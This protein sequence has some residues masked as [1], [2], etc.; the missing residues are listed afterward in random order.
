MD[1]RS[2]Q[3]PVRERDE[4]IRRI[5]ET[6]LDAVVSMDAHGFVRYWNTPAE[7]MFGWTSSEVIGEDLADLIMPERFR[8]AHRRGIKR[9]LVTG[10][11]P[12]LGRRIET[13]GLRRDGREFPIELSV[14]ALVADG[15]HTFNAFISDITERKQAEQLLRTGEAHKTSLLR[16]S[17]RLEES[18]SV[19]AVLDAALTEVKTVMGYRTLW[20]YLLAPDGETASL[21]SVAGDIAGRAEREVPVLKVRGDR[22]LEACFAAHDVLV[23]DDAAVD[24]RTNKG[25]VAK[26]EVRTIVT[27]PMLLADRRIGTLGTGSVGDEGVRA[28]DPLQ[29]DYF[30]ALA[31]HV[32]VACGRIRLLSD[33]ARAIEEARGASAA[34]RARLDVM[35]RVIDDLLALMDGDGAQIGLAAVQRIVE[36]HGGE[37]RARGDGGTGYSFTLA[38]PAGGRGPAVR[39]PRAV[40]DGPQQGFMRPGS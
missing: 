36:K 15:V 39:T 32:A 7:A 38:P 30:R 17:R 5:L 24:E 19:A 4:Q 31:A 23:I 13:T 29:R 22:F 3:D 33:G 21:L 14:V 12:I 27:A 37:I 35:E 16:L 40:L 2:T 1:E 20:A 11:G 9:F 18:E 8:E 34:L 10:R 28:P 26:L 25:I 6:S